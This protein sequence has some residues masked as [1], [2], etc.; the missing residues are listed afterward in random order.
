[1]SSHRCTMG[2]KLQNMTLKGYFDKAF[3]NR[4]EQQRTSMRCSFTESRRLSLTLSSERLT[5]H[6]PQA[7]S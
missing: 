3:G 2:L 1:M 5:V 6:Y 4:E 7:P